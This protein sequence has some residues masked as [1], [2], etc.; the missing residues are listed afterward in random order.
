MRPWPC[1]P[2]HEQKEALFHQ[3]VHLSLKRNMFS[4][5]FANVTYSSHV[6]PQPRRSPRSPPPSVLRVQRK[7]RLGSEKDQTANSTAG[8]VITEWKLNNTNQVEKRDFMKVNAIF[9][10]FCD[11]LFGMLCRCNGRGRARA[12]RGGL[13]YS[14]P[15][16]AGDLLERGPHG[17]DGG[18]IVRAIH[19]SPSVTRERRQTNC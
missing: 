11:V 10:C 17:G 12:R 13:S 18:S 5:V 7:L 8:V 4:L 9:L 16:D 15:I 1:I 3:N 2:S 14:G 6:P 19:L